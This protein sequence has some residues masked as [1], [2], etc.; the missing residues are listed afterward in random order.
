MTTA[1]RIVVGLLPL[2]DA[3]ADGAAFIT[4]VLN[5]ELRKYSQYTLSV[6]H[7]SRPMVQTLQQHADLNGHTGLPAGLNVDD[8]ERVQEALAS[9]RAPATRRV[10]ASQW[11]R[12]TA[13]AEQREVP[14]LPTSPSAIAAYLSERAASGA[15]IAMRC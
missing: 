2:I 9:A 12:F 15:S 11:R 10:Y 8:A 14:T 7:T 5:K 1:F 6:N 3:C 13:W 4:H